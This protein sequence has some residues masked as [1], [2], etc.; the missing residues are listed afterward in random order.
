MSLWI[1]GIRVSVDRGLCRVCTLLVHC[2][3]CLRVHPGFGSI[4]SSPGSGCVDAR[5]CVWVC[6]SVLVSGSAFLCQ[7]LCVCLCQCVLGA[8]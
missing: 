7:Y 2:R 4:I 6:A 5:V 3:V 8:E 1:V